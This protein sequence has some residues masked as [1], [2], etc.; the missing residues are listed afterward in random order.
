MYVAVPVACKFVS[1]PNVPSVG[2]FT[3]F[4]VVVVPVELVVTVVY[5]QGV[6]AGTPGSQ[7]TFVLV[8]PTT[9]AVRVVD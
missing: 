1:V 7:L 2:Q 6:P 3:G 5:V 4:D 8:G 9:V